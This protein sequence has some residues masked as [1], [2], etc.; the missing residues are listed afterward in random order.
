MT[1]V[2]TGSVSSY[3]AVAVAAAL[4]SAVG[5]WG[6][7][8]LVATSVAQP[9]VGGAV[10]YSP[11][12]SLICQDARSAS[13]CWIGSPEAAVPGTAIPDTTLSDTSLRGPTSLES[14]ASP[15]VP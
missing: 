14:T 7:T 9:A 8:Q 2:R 13:A 3:A 6:A 10:S 1:I 11:S 5:T 15:A 4:I 12:R